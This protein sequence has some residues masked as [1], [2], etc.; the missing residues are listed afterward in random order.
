M[1]MKPLEAEAIAQRIIVLILVQ[2][3]DQRGIALE[4]VLILI[5]GIDQSII[6]QR[7]LRALRHQQPF[8]L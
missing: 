2:G 7:G 6:N 8:P 3:I 1:N 5:Q 4:V